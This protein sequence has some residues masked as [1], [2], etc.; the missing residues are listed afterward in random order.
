MRSA[1]L[2]LA[3]FTLVGV[4]GEL[5]GRTMDV[6][7]WWIGL[8]DLPAVARLLLLAALAGLL[9]AWA[10]RPAPGPKLRWSTAAVCGVFAGF[11][12][13]DVVR[14]YAAVAEGDVRP[15]I[16]VPLSLLIALLLVGLALGALR[17][18]HGR[19]VPGP[20]GAIALAV[21]VGAWA[22]VFPLAQMLFFGT[23][24]HRRPADAA[25]I[26]GARVYASGQPSPL[27]A[28][29]IRTGVELYRSG[30]VP[31]LVMSGGDGSDGF[32]EARVMRD[33][34]VA[35]GV[36]PAAILVDPAGNSTEATV[37]NVSALLATRNGPRGPGRVIAVSQAYHLPRVQLA[38][39]SAGIDVLTVPAAD[40]EPIGEMP[41]LVAR[42]ILAFWA[43]DLRVCLG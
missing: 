11:A 7:L 23:T 31:L 8:G 10:I 26:F 12:I 30:L 20:R 24:D 14:F 15:F 21:G 41:L 9:A 5:R 17:A 6:S 13:R 1:A 18:R 16:D 22:I 4:V 2:F 37:A 39:A 32:N 35:A 27:L 33:V 38:F 25:V 36:D 19:V 29:R 42:E 40:P 3:A 28:D 34:A 43:Y